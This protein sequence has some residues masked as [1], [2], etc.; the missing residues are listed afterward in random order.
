MLKCHKED[1]EFQAYWE[2]NNCRVFD[3][4]ED[5]TIYRFSTGMITKTYKPKVKITK[6]E[7]TKLF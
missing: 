4:V 7:Q 3:D 2:K 5:C 1:C 6:G